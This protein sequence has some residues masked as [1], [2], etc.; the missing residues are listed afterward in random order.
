MEA[1]FKAPKKLVFNQDI[2]NNLNSFLDS[3]EIYLVA[4]GLKDKD[5]E[6]KVAILL[7]I[8][9]EEAQ[10]KF[11]TFNLTSEEKKNFDT[12]VA[13]FENYCKPL[14]N[15]TYDRYKFFTRKQQEGETFDS[16]VT[17]IKDLAN[18][19]NFGTLQ[20]SLIRDRI[21]S[22]ILDASLQERLLQYPQLTLVK[23]EVL[24]RS[25]ETSKKQARELHN[26][27]EVDAV[28]ESRYKNKNQV[29]NTVQEVKDYN[30]FKC[31]KRHGPRSCPAFGKKCSVCKSGVEES[32]D[33][34]PSV[35][36]LGNEELDEQTRP[37]DMLALQSA[38]MQQT[39]MIQLL[40]NQQQE[41][42]KVL[43]K[44]MSHPSSTG[45]SSSNPTTVVSTDKSGEA[46]S[47]GNGRI[48]M[49]GAGPAKGRPP[50]SAH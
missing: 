22:G 47:T 11:R 38:L 30:C 39:R 9:G 7:N 21:V 15:E 13:A 48:M 6:T 27:K 3:L 45:A 32:R 43:L 26:E 49:V 40:V 12:V 36:S 33:P 46:G 1:T 42:N 23:A 31:G 24:C 20:D 5:D 8:A 10:K 37:S 34:N 29:R 35:N 19:C 18:L 4:T 16:F 2:H 50:N 28:G 41:L 14:R 44:S 25:S 17:D